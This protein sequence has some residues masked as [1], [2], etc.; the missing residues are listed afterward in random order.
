MKKLDV[1]LSNLA[2]ANTYLHNLHW[3]LSGDKAF[4]EAHVYLEELYTQAFEYF[5][6]V[7]ELQIMLGKKPLSS[8]KDYMDNA[9]LKDLEKFDFTVTEALK[10]ALEYIKLMKELSLEVRKESDEEE[11]F[12]VANMMEDHYT[13][14]IKHEW[15]LS[16]MLK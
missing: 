9:T 16:S 2:V 3:N 7:A 4:K 14:Y 13:E 1:Y 6:E 11:T 8:M 10:H 5:D 12:V 15:F